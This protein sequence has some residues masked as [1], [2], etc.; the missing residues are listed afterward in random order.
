MKMWDGR[1]RKPSDPIM[2]SLNRSLDIDNRLIEEDIQGSVAWAG[3][4]LGCDVLSSVEHRSIVDGLN[5]LLS[6]HREKG[7]L[8]LASDEDIHMAVERLLVEKIGEPGM[9]LHTGRSRN[10]QVVTDVR[11]YVKKQYE[12]LCR[13]LVALQ[14]ALLDRSEGDLSIIMPG[15]T[16]LQQAQPVLIS[17]Y[18]CSLFFALEREKT[19]CDNASSL[20]DCMPLG[21]GA[22]A[23]SGFAVDR[24]KLA[25][26]L[27][28]SECS[29][30]SIDAVG[31]RDF[32]IDALGCCTSIAILLSRYAEDLIIWSSKEFG[33]VELDDAWSTGS[34]MMPQ[35]K[36]P[37]SLEL[38]RSKA[39]RCIGNY[40][41][42]A[43][44]LNGVGLAYYKD[45][46]EDKRPL[47]DS[48][49][50]MTLVC[51][52]FRHVI[53]TLA[54]KKDAIRRALDPF[55]LATDA[56]DYLVKKG[57]PFRQAHKVIG[58]M[59]AHCV[60]HRLDFQKL[61]LETLRKFSLLFEQDV[62]DILNWEQSIAH[63][64]VFGGTGINSVKEQISIARDLLKNG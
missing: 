2:E 36:N 17:H 33:F 22:I 27:G 50:Q 9:K 19:R 54:V 5:S 10:D 20:A 49:D 11:M 18:W 37:D 40:T 35:K 23:G 30:N 39:G 48:F 58:A 55:L 41:G 32:I 56:A 7:L 3:A 45:L 44:T 28:F 14:K 16:H 60:E 42:F 1:F 4:L 59:V 46:Q 52:V 26:E 13:E 53:E 51:R 61:D 57:M 6:E 43:A 24:R 47:F 64:G 12:A 29:S 31:S 34:S 38:I 15:Y 63:R 62:M 25:E 8:F 21:S